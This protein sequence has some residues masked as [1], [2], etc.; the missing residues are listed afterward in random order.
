MTNNAREKLEK[1]LC[2]LAAMLTWVGPEDVTPTTSLSE[3]GLDSLGGIELLAH[4]EAHFGVMFPE[5]N[6]PPLD[7]VIEIVNYAERAKKEI[8]EVDRE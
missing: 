6:I 2:E 5:K 1:E 3:I 8:F 7:T 4:V